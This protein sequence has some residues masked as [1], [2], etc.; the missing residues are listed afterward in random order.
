MSE[1]QR[2]D[3]EPKMPVQHVEASIHVLSEKGTGP[4][5]ERVRVL[6]EAKEPENQSEVGSFLGLANYSAVRSPVS[7]LTEPHGS[8]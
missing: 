2:P 5:E 8:C 7:T 4:T 6:V 1:G 3:V